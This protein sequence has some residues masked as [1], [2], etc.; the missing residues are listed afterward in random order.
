MGGGETPVYPLFYAQV[1]KRFKG[2]DIYVGG[3]NLA[4]YRQ[5]DIIIG[6]PWAPDFDASQVWGPI[7]GAK[8]YAGM[9]F[10]LWKKA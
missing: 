2:V 5:K 7:M 4:G 10:T 3:E 9:R 8:I 6:T 1:T